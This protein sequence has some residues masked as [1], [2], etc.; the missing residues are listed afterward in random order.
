[1]IILPLSA[2]MLTAWRCVKVPVALGAAVW[3]YNTQS[4]DE[5]TLAE[6]GSLVIGFF[7]FKIA[8]VLLLY[9]ELRPRFGS[10]VPTRRIPRMDDVE[11]ISFDIYARGTKKLQAIE[12]ADQILAQEEEKKRKRQG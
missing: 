10:D 7:S 8:H 2:L 1:M 9:R 12:D 6:Q 4:G 5:L 11:D 3:L